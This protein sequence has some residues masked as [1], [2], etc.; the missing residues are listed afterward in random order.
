MTSSA[1]PPDIAFSNQPSS[2]SDQKVKYGN[3]IP[4]HARADCWCWS[5][6]SDCLTLNIWKPEYADESSKLPVLLY[7][8]VR[9]FSLELHSLS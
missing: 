1:H 4:S 8:H 7:I 6:S 5:A 2:G 3:A 9:H